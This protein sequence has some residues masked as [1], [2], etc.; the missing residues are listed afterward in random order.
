MGI[1]C[2]RVTVSLNGKGYKNYGHVKC[3]NFICS[4]LGKWEL[5][6]YKYFNN[7]NEN[8]IYK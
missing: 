2:L 7:E 5:Y 4:S 3:D 6:N 8:I 1:H